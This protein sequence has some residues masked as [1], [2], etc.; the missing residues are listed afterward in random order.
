MSNEL[1]TLYPSKNHMYDLDMENWN[2]FLEH[3]K[4]VAQ[5]YAPYDIDDPPNEMLEEMMT[6]DFKWIL[7]PT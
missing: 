3:A 2:D 6:F 7:I 1:R 5:K 4:K